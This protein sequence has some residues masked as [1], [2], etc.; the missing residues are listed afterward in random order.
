MLQNIAGILL[1]SSAM[2]V[3]GVTERFVPEPS[4][5]PTLLQR[6]DFPI[7]IAQQR[8]RPDGTR[9]GGPP[10]R[11][12][13]DGPLPEASRDGGSSE[14]WD[15][16]LPPPS[17]ME[18][19]RR[20]PPEERERVLRNNWRFRQ[21]PIERQDQLLDRMRQFQRLSQIERERIEERFSIFSNLTPEQQG[22]ARK[23]Y[24]EHWRK[25]EPARRRAIV[26]EFRSLRELSEK[27][28]DKRLKSK[29]IK[30]GFNQ[31]ELEVLKQLA[32]L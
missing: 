11:R 26:E 24:Q 18:R 8:D 13:P 7:W 10:P 15:R 1:L 21:L 17:V 14:D 16:Q 4:A 9:R 25:L 5:E 27:E 23:V 19:L 20:L 2:A 22:K 12:G 3:A 6:S 28:R 32:K 31:Q 29:E 30:N